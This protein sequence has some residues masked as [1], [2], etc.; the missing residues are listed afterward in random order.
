MKTF[1]ASLFVRVG[2]A[3]GIAGTVTYL[4]IL[5]GFQKLEETFRALPL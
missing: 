5:P 1:F 3:L 2:F 4:Y